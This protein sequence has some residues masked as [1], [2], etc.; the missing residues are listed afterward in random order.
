M[1][2]HIHILEQAAIAG[3]HDPEV[4]GNAE[5]ADQVVNIAEGGLQEINSLSDEDLDTYLSEGQRVFGRISAMTCCT[6]AAINGAALGGGLELALHCDVLLGMTP[7]FVALLSLV[8]TTER[9]PL[10]VWL[11]IGLV[12]YFAYGFRRSAARD[13]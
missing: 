4:L 2:S 5:R 10:G 3:A 9:P 12:F 8:L 11:G 6:V 1:L 7:V 13:G